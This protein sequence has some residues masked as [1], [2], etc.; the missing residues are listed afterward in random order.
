MKILIR[1]IV[2]GKLESHRTLVGTPVTSIIR[3]RVIAGEQKPS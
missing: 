1:V 2:G 3:V